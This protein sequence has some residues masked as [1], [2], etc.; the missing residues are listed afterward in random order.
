[1]N[2]LFKKR[3]EEEE[4]KIERVDKESKCIFTCSLE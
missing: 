1:L 3:G 4:K 2:I